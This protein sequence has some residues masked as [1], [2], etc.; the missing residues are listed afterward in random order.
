MFRAGFKDT[1]TV[2]I[3]YIYIYIYIYR[4]NLALTNV[5]FC[6]GHTSPKRKERESLTE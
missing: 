5:Y 3:K 6:H 4:E 2:L 1:K